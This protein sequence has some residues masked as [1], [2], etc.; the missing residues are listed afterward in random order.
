M[1]YRVHTASEGVQ[2]QW[3]T[4]AELDQAFGFEH[5]EGQEND[6]F[7]VLNDMGNLEAWVMPEDPKVLRA[8]AEKILANLGDGQPEFLIAFELDEGYDDQLAAYLEDPSAWGDKPFDWLD[9]ALWSLVCPDCGAENG[10]VEVDMSE[11]WNRLDDELEIADGQLH[12]RAGTGDGNYDHEHFLCTG[13]YA[14]L[15]APDYF[16]ITDW[17]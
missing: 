12:V 3:G 16:E 8:L 4:A 1:T 15:S 17:S 6:R 13:C 9:Y 2:V 11:R 10:I 5:P 14:K 7:M